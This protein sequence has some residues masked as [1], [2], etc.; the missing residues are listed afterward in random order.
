MN[1]AIRDAVTEFIFLKQEPVKCDVIL[2]PGGSFWELPAR[3]AEL[4][5]LGLAEYILP[6]G[7]YSVSRGRFM[8][9]NTVGT[10]YEGEYETEYAFMRHVLLDRGVPG[11]AILRE[12]SQSGHTEDNARLSR[13]V[14][15]GLGIEPRSAM[16]CCKASHARRV[17]MTYA[18]HFPE[19]ALTVVPVEVDGISR[20]TWHQTEN[21]I[22]RVMGELER[23]G[24]YFT[25]AYVDE[26]QAAKRGD[27]T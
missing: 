2:I 5:G 10:P 23:C 24:K 13:Q 15:D 19:T 21:G 11:T 12:E 8:H 1:N 4:Y 3:A 17:Q 6:S 14:L 27:A 26:I 16:L 20:E 22:R 7:R 25:D 9:E 18:L